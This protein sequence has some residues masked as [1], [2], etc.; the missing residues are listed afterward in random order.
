L[1]VA[2]VLAIASAVGVAGV[3]AGLWIWLSILRFDG[4]V[5]DLGHRLRESQGW[6]Q[7][8][9]AALPELVRSYAVRAGGRIGAT[10]V[11]HS[12]QHASL[13]IAR[14]RPP[15]EIEADQ[16]TGT[17]RPGIV[18]S[19]RGRMNGLPVSV[20]DAFVSGSGELLA[21]LAGLV[22]VA[23]GRGADYDKGELMRYLSELPVHPD[24]ILN[25]ASL[26]WRMID[27]RTAEVSARSATGSATLRFIF[28]EAGDVARM[29]ADDRPM[30]VGSATVP[31]PWQGSYRDYRQYGAY[32]L[33]AHGEVG[34]LLPD[35]LFTY[36]R[37]ELVAYEPGH[38]GA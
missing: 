23:G 21:K 17:V 28:D 29:E 36:W 16:W 26:K 24:A 33:P 25:V 15:V 10:D 37:G 13:T 14:D 22:K 30:S 12:R 34:W 31:M 35:G 20:L 1:L 11:I 6:P 18:W 38:P 4:H 3:V 9:A 2:W 5:A 7:P 27:Q 19:A 32:R 8:G